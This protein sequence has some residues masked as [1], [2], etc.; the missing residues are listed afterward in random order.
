MVHSRHDNRPPTVARLIQTG[1]VIAYPTEAVFGLG[2]DPAQAHAVARVLALKGRNSDKGFIVVAADLRD[3]DHW[4]ETDIVSP[5]VEQARQ[6]A[7]STWCWPL[8]PACPEWLRGT[9]SSLAVRI[10]AWPP[11]R[12]LLAET[13]PLLSTSANRSGEPAC[14]DAACVKRVFGDTIDLILDGATGGEAQPSPV[15]IAAT[16]ECLR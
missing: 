15:R 3:L 12:H 1:G 2:C 11:L 10:P 7:F 8:K 16:G 4:I 14:R 13:G 9:H 5:Y 6:P